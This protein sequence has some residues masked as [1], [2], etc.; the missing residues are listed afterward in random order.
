MTANGQ[1]SRDAG[2]PGEPRLPHESDGWRILSYMLGGMILYGGIGWLIGRWTGIPIL[3][4]VG[5]I[6]GLALSIVLIILRVS[7]S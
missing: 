4:P 5:M 7:R 3:F 6:A 1:R 2:D